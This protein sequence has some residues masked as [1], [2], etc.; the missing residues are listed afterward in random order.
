[1]ES[2]PSLWS[3]ACDRVLFMP[4]YTK[5]AVRFTAASALATL[6]LFFSLSGLAQLDVHHSFYIGLPGNGLWNEELYPEN[7]LERYT[8]KEVRKVGLDRWWSWPCSEVTA[9]VSSDPMG[10]SEAGGPLQKC[11]RSRQGNLISLSLLVGSLW[12][13]VCSWEGWFLGWRTV[14]FEDTSVSLEQQNI[15]RSWGDGHVD[16]DG[17]LGGVS[18]D[19]LHHQFLPF[20]HWWVSLL[21]ILQNTHMSSWLYFRLLVPT[22]KTHCHLTTSWVILGLEY[23]QTTMYRVMAVVVQCFKN[24]VSTYL[25]LW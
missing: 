11:P 20:T 7:A 19:P 23:W 5:T 4:T 25:E 12:E 10:G 9:K 24:Y 8:C 22:L 6:P 16:P 14:P 18:H 13:G 21:W 17:N 15:S 1:M 3:P 2:N